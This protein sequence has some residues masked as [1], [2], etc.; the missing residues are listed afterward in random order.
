MLAIGNVPGSGNS[1]NTKKYILSVSVGLQR[2]KFS[3]RCLHWRREEKRTD[4]GDIYCNNRHSDWNIYEEEI[5]TW[6]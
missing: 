1:T 5:C 4:V 3:I 2:R 6:L